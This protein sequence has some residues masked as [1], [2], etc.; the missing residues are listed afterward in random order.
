[1]GSARTTTPSRTTSSTPVRAAA[2]T[3]VK[4]TGEVLFESGKTT[5]SST[6]TKTLDTMAAT[7][8]KSHAGE[9]LIIEGFTDSTPVKSSA[10]NLKSN[11]AIATARATAVKNYLAKKGIPE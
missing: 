8:K 1:R 7:I 6:A 4:I 2:P 10:T 9:K 11:D 5:L 3:H